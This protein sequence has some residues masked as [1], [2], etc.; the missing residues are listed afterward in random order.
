MQMPRLRSP[1][2]LV[3]GLFG[4]SRVRLGSWVKFDYF[5]G[6]PAALEA[7]GN[8]AVAAKLHPTGGIAQ[9][10]EQLK[11]FLQREFP[12]EPVHLLAHSMGGLDSRYMISR[13]GMADRVLT[14]TTLGTPH[15]GSPFADYAVQRLVPLVAPM[16]DLLRLPREAFA[17]LTVARCRQFNEE[18]PDAPGVRYFSVAGRYRSP[19]Y[20]PSWGLSAPMIEKAEGPCDGIVSVASATWGEGCEVWEGDHM[21]LINWTKPGAVRDPVGRLPDYARLLGRLRDEGY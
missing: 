20:H 2:V 1:V 11:A 4:F 16:F 10:A 17:D 14:L 5:R 12:G 21:S 13:L 7:G 6:V 8:R 15:R 3:H 19:W 18:T 9:R